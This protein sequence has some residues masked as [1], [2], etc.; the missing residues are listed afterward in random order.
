VPSFSVSSLTRFG[1]ASDWFHSSNYPGIY[2][3]LTNSTAADPVVINVNTSAS[4]SGPSGAVESAHSVVVNPGG[5]GGCLVI[6][7]SLASDL[8]S[9]ATI[10]FTIDLISDSSDGVRAAMYAAGPGSSTAAVVDGPVTDPNMAA[11]A[12][13]L[14]WSVHHVDGTTIY[15]VIDNNATAF[16]DNAAITFTVAYS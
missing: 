14:S 13:S 9:T 2:G 5:D 7:L 4:S 10:N 15:V 1:S 3:Y 12:S 6:G 16:N 8:T 11:A